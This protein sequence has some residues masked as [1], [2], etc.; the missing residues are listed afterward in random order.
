MRKDCE[1]GEEDWHLHGLLGKPFVCPE[2]TAVVC[3]YAFVVC[4]L[5][6]LFADATALFSLLSWL[7]FFGC[8]SRRVVPLALPCCGL[9][10]LAWIPK[11]GRQ[12]VYLKRRRSQKGYID[13]AAWLLCCRFAF[14]SL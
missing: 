11:M 9:T 14:E 3:F 10:L 1:F 2:K 12:S 8:S 6:P 13:W 5:S 7:L 4:F